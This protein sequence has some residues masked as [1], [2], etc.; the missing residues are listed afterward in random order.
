MTASLLTWDDQ[1][2]SIS[3][4]PGQRQA[5]VV[6]QVAEARRL[7]ALTH[8]AQ[9][10]GSS[11]RVARPAGCRL[12][13]ISPEHQLPA[14][15]S[16]IENMRLAMALSRDARVIAPGSPEDQRCHAALTC[17]AAIVDLPAAARPD[18]LSLLQRLAAQWALA[19]LLPHDL[20]WLDRPAQGLSPREQQQMLA[21][22]DAHRRHY[23]LR[24]Q[25]Y[26]DLVPP[27]R[28]W[29]TTST[30]FWG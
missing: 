13:A 10:L 20:L 19:W 30:V 6:E 11:G 16:V 14:E 9:I 18:E 24:A 12:L 5:V 23:P 21:L 27:G 22:S 3:L 8:R 17:I 4:A 1:N 15:Y 28:D 29:A 26:A 7:L 25:V 2:G